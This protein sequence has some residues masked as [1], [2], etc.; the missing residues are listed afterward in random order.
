MLLCHTFV[1]WRIKLTREKTNRVAR[2]N[3]IFCWCGMLTACVSIELRV[4]VCVNRQRCLCISLETA[5]PPIYASLN[6][7]LTVI[8]CNTLR[9]RFKYEKNHTWTYPQYTGPWTARRFFTWSPSA[10]HCFAMHRY[11][12]E[13]YIEFKRARSE[14]RKKNGSNHI[15]THTGAHTLTHDFFLTSSLQMQTQIAVHMRWNRRHMKFIIENYEITVHYK[16][17]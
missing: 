14:R 16:M 8:V 10:W 6:G 2:N 3:V 1:H 5:L 15:G 11:F 12:A 13:H 9:V 17:W 7:E 4:C